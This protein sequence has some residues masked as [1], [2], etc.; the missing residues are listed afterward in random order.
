MNM[1]TDNDKYAK[2]YDYKIPMSKTSAAIRIPKKVGDD[3]I[4]SQLVPTEIMKQNHIYIPASRTAL[5]GI[6]M[7]KTK[8]KTK[9]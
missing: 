2:M 8:G 6:D 7:I 9:E 4:L 3:K 1:P 5:E